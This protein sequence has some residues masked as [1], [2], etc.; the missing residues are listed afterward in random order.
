MTVESGGGQLFHLTS[1]CLELCFKVFRLQKFKLLV[2]DETNLEELGELNWKLLLIS[3]YSEI[4]PFFLT[5]FLES[6][7]GWKTTISIS[8][9]QILKP[10]FFFCSRISSVSSDWSVPKSPNLHYKDNVLSQKT[11]L[12]WFHIFAV[13]LFG[14]LLNARFV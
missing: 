7:M 2:I 4:S 6:I 14:S 12:P 5:S 3:N 8:M 9:M 10:D 11:C 13:G 1:K